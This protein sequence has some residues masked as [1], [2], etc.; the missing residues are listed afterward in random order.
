MKNHRISDEE[1]G[2]IERAK[3]GDN[4][5]FSTLYRNYEKYV[6]KI[7]RSYVKDA[8]TAEYLTVETFV[9]VY[10]NI[11]DF[12]DYKSFSAWVKTIAKNIAIDCLREKRHVVEVRPS[13]ANR[14]SSEEV[15]ETRGVGIVDQLTI[16][17]IM[18]TFKTLPKKHQRICERF[19]IDEWTAKDIAD[20]LGIPVGTVKSVLSRVRKRLKKQFKNP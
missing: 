16:E 20:N 14:L 17:R 6:F 1:I 10:E 9:K 18:K 5:A 15:L 7:I 13:D 2:L 3:A 4:N 19:Y 11:S 12:T 8:D